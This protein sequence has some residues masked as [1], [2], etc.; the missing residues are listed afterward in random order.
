MAKPVVLLTGASAGIGEALARRL[1]QDRRDRVLSARR[2][3]RLE[4][5]AGEVE[6]G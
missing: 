3:D 1:A 4:A 5:L 2:V 6:D